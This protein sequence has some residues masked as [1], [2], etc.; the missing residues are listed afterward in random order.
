MLGS[1]LLPP[2]TVILLSLIDQ[3]VEK[4]STQTVREVMLS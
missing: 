2:C 1:A 4:Q 3:I